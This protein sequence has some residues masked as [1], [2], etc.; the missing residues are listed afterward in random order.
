MCFILYCLS[1]TWNN[2]ERLPLDRLI[3]NVQ[4]EQNYIMKKFPKISI[5]TIVNNI[6]NICYFRN[7]LR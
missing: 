5:K 3:I 4:L 7:S 1:K 2:K 6:F